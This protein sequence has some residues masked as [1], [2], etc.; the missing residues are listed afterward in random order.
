[1]PRPAK[2]ALGFNDR[3]LR[4]V[5]AGERR[6]DY[7]D[8]SLHG[9][10]LIVRPTG[11][12]TYF[13]RYRLGGVERRILLGD[14]PRVPLVDARSAAK[15]VLGR[16]ARGEDPQSDPPEKLAAP[17]FGDLAA[18]YLE[19]HA[20][21]RTRTWKED[22]RILRCDLLPAWPRIPAAEYRRRD[23][24]ALLDEIVGRG[25]PVIANSVRSLPSQI[26]AFALERDVVEFNP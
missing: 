8:L 17:T 11:R 16:V 23:V 4:A 9:F 21:R 5:R 1:M 12:K 10:G 22:E 7:M 3:S 6:L 2:N 25:A 24:A 19:V 15:D 20:K 13:V 18:S 14:Y 26:F